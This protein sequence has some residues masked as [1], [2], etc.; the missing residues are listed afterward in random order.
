VSILVG[1]LV[2]SILNGIYFTSGAKQAMALLEEAQGQ[3][4]AEQW[5]EAVSLAQQAEEEWMSQDFYHHLVLS[6]D[7]LDELA[8]E[9]QELRHF[10][11]A[12]DAPEAQAAAGRLI[13]RLDLAAREEQFL[14]ENFL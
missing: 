10:L 9:F 7:I 8:E 13:T 3:V 14:P 11:A 12:Q 1:V 4:E 6:A 2:A 5:E